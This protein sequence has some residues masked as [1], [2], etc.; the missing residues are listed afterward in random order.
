MVFIYSTTY[1]AARRE[2]SADDA[3]LATQFLLLQKTC[4]LRAGG[5]L[6]KTP[7]PATHTAHQVVPLH[8]PLRQSSRHVD[9]KR[10]DVVAESLVAPAAVRR[11]DVEGG[12][13]PL[14]SISVLVGYNSVETVDLDVSDEG[15][16]LLDGRP[17]FLGLGLL[18]G[19]G[20]GLARLAG[21]F[22]HGLLLM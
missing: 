11:L 21:L 19:L 12:V 9:A 8:R 1:S 18:P 2:A 10:A 6:D 16:K 14:Q 17:N 3:N 7:C 13:V 20:F 22:G 5:T 15:V 4:E